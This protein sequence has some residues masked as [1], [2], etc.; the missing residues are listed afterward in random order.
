MTSWHVPRLGCTAESAYLPQA[1]ETE[2]LTGYARAES[3][4][5]ARDYE[6]E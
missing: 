5:E 6:A 2:G 3:D 4:P 1:H